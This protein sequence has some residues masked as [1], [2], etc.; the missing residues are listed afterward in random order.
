MGINI[1]FMGS[2][3]FSTP[4][5]TLLAQQYHIA[6]VVTQPDRHAGRGRKLTSPPIKELATS[7]EIP[8]IQ[9]ESIKQENA[10]KEMISWKP[11]L[12]VVAA[13]GKILR[14]NILTLPRFGCLNVHASLLPRW[15]GASPVEAAIECGDE[16]TGVTIMIMDRG[17][18][19]GPI[20]TSVKVRITT[21]ETSSSLSNKLSTIGAKLLVDTIP[22]YI[23]KEIIPIPQDEQEATYAPMINKSDGELN[24]SLPAVQLERK[25]RAYTPWPGTFTIW[26]NTILKIHQATVV[27]DIPNDV[28]PNPGER[29]IYEGKPAIITG[30]GLLVIE[31]IQQAGRKQ[32]QGTEF[33]RGINNW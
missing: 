10:L 5:L 21:D 19:T 8:I 13:Y 11:D 16:Y 25:I 28:T 7:L 31:R 29:I 20:L 26:N 6:G 23:N 12:I 33:I 30:E 14:D 9:P 17:L 1:V 2:A 18:D 15:R 27:S 24:F 4:V 22:L 3:E 32:I